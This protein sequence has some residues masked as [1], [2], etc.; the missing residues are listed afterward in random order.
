MSNKFP[1][2]TNL[3]A[4]A[5]L[6]HFLS[7]PAGPYHIDYSDSTHL[8]ADEWIQLASLTLASNQLGFAGEDLNIEDGETVIHQSYEIEIDVKAP[9]VTLDE[10]HQ[11]VLLDQ[12]SQCL[13]RCGIQKPLL[14]PETVREV[15]RLQKQKSVLIIPDTN[16]LANGS[17]HWLLSALGKTSTHLVPITISL[18][19]LQEHDR[20]LKSM[21]NKRALHNLRPA[22]R[23]RALVNH[24]FAM[25]DICPQNYQ[26]LEVPPE[27]LRYVRP[28][29]SK[30]GEQDESDVLE[31][32]LLI[33]AIHQVLRATRSKSPK[34]VITGDVT[35]SRVLHTE[36]IPFLSV[37]VPILEKNSRFSSFYFDSIAKK[38]RGAPLPQLMWTLLQ[39]FSD[40]RIR[41][42]SNKVVC[43]MSL[44]WPSK[45]IDDWIAHKFLFD[46]MSLSAI[47]PV[48]PF[49]PSANTAPKPIPPSPVVPPELSVLKDSFAPSDKRVSTSELRVAE[50][51]DGDGHLSSMATPNISLLPIIQLASLASKVG[52]PEVKY[53]ERA[54]SKLNFSDAQT[55]NAGEVLI[56]CGLLCI[57]QNMVFATDL[58]DILEM[59]VD[60]NQLDMISDLFVNTFQP[61]QM[62]LMHLKDHGNL[63][64][65][66]EESIRS[67]W[68]H[69]SKVAYRSLRGFLI[70]LGQAWTADGQLF[71]GS[72][73]PDDKQFLQAIFEVFKDKDLLSVSELTL[74]L[75]R[76]LKMST[77][78]ANRQLEKLSAKE[79]LS[80]FRFDPATPSEPVNSEKLLQGPFNN[81]TLEPFNISSIYVGGKP[82]FTVAR[83]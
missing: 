11:R 9:N 71:D 19:Q 22:L 12:I 58:V 83:A 25:L 5:V 70:Y 78:A 55:R 80:A 10:G 16:A 1:I 42:A 32:R 50:I 81:P 74:T 33:E 31:D 21:V 61:Y 18:H 49:E 65:D 63:P 66:L 62:L 76:N 38:F 3:T 59:R 23:S 67:K 6:E 60:H 75:S 39:V 14:S 2:P 44:Y 77:W 69:S 68:P 28:S 45:T 57:K 46:T 34:M 30:K 79:S 41:N 36:A 40:V 13:V 35:M 51:S 37:L 64:S 47:T 17:L 53:F 8:A 52:E 43:R 56:K 24:S 72:N 54:L 15:I 82:V 4:G 20:N 26:V 48:E 7:L 73:R 27:L 29:S